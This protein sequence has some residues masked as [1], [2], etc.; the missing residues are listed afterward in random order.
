MAFNL[1]LVFI[2]VAGILYLDVYE[3]HLVEAEQRALV[4]VAWVLATAL[5]PTMG[6]EEVQRA[7][8]AAGI[9]DTRLRVVDREGRVI[10]DSYRYRVAP[11]E[12]Q[13]EVDEIR[14]HPLYRLGAFFLRKPMK[15]LSREDELPQTADAYE[16]ATRLEGAEVKTALEG[17]IGLARRR[18]S[19]SVLLYV[20]VPVKKPQVIGAVVAS[21]PTSSVLRGVYAV[22]LGVSRIFVASVVFAMLLSIWIGA[23]I[24][25]PIR[26]LRLAAHEIL[27]QTG[28]LRGRFRALRRHD[29]IGDLA[30]ALERLT[31]RLEEH[32]NVV[33]S[34][35]SDVSHELKNP[36]ASIRNATELL[37]SVSDP[38]E[39]RRFLGVIEKE[40]ARMEK[41]IST[42]R[43]VTVIDAQI[44]REERQE[45][46]LAPLLAQ[47]VEGFQTREKESVR[48]E[49]N[50]ADLGVRASEERLS[51]V[52]EN[53]LDN[54][55]SFSPA[56]G[57]VSVDALRDRTEAILRVSDEGPGI[58][59]EHLDRIFDRFFTYRPAA[60]RDEHTGLGLAIVKAI[61]EGYGGRVRAMNRQPNGAT[62]EVR[63][64]LS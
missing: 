23:T 61:V 43:E 41:L 37:G 27:D 1:L 57:V 31:T 40:V 10:A 42:L 47:I 32:Q 22:R 24:V 11:E 20:A 12:F 21:V 38:A 3:E 15:L 6:A 8:H 19:S 52:I 55:A 9:M 18:G 28:R 34:F 39:R 54:A 45:V 49:L 56:G 51:Q 63:L 64:P 48:F 60:R 50:A 36:L 53:L 5:P 58:P 26:A 44:A 35:A 30:R 13:P 62:V 14:E 2:P 46:R 4:R 33:E 25:R 17:D 29:E 7:L 59:E 16:T